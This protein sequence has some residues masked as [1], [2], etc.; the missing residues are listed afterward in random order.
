MIRYRKSQVFITLALA[1]GLIFTLPVPALA[2]SKDKA[3][4]GNRPTIGTKLIKGK[5]ST[6]TSDNHSFVVAENTTSSKTIKVDA[7]TK[8]Y[9]VQAGPYALN[10]RERVQEQIQDFRNNGPNN[11]NQRGLGDKNKPPEPEDEVDSA[12]N[13]PILEQGLNENWHGPKGFL[14][15]L[16]SWLGGWHGFGNKADFS[17]LSPG[18]G[19]IVR[20]MPNENLAKQ[21]LIIKPSSLKKI[22]GKII[23]VTSDNFTVRSD[24]SADV[25]FTVGENTSVELKGALCLA[26]GQWVSVIYKT[27]PSGSNLAMTVKAWKQ[28]PAATSNS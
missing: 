3:D 15:K 5:V 12:L 2:Q 1:A 16:K 10:I 27:Q 11:M 8:Y 22:S 18:D 28:K 26:T 9:L 4:T 23:S 21:V 17:D 25:V 14:D 20:I 7:N 24:S 13:N 6:I 19:V